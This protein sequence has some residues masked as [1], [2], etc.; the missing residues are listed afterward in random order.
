MTKTERDKIRGGVLE[1]ANRVN[2]Y[3]RPSERVRVKLDLVLT[4]QAA[5]NYKVTKLFAPGVT[6]AEFVHL[7]FR[8]GVQ[9]GT[10]I[11]KILAPRNGIQI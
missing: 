4:D 6:D 3:G 9:N 7:L 10:E 11:I 8:L 5:I 2:K 1:I